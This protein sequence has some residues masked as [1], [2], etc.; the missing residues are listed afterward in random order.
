[1]NEK[2]SRARAA[3]H[4]TWQRPWAHR[5]RIWAAVVAVAARLLL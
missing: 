4:R 2:I 3:V 1:M 5:L